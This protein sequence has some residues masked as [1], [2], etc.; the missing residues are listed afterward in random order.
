[1][2][3]KSSGPGTTFP[4]QLEAVLK[5]PPLL[6]IQWMVAPWAVPSMSQA[7]IHKGRDKFRI[8]RVTTSERFLLPDNDS[9][10][11]SNCR[12]EADHT[13]FHFGWQRKNAVKLTT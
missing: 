7:A 2:M 4:L 1:M 10:L 5:L 6:F 8:Y 11:W 9:V 12:D 3:A 13:E